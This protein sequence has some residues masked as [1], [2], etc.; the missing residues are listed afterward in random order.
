MKKTYKHL[1]LREREKLYGWLKAGF[2]L[3]ETA[4]RL[5]RD[6]STIS[7]ELKRNAPPIRTGYYLPAKAQVRAL[8]RNIKSRTRLRL[9]NPEIRSYV[10]RKLKQDPS[11]EQIAGRLK[12]EKSSMGISHEAIYQFIYAE[13]RDFIPL[14]A[15]SHRKR[16]KRWHT[17]KHRKSHIPQ[18]VPITQRPR[19]VEARCQFGHWEA[20][21]IISRVSLPSLLVMIE[22]KSR[23]VKLA[24]LPQKSADATRT[25]INRR[26]SQIPSGLRRTVTY[27][28]GSENVEHLMVNETVGTRSYFCLPFHSWEKGAVENTAGLVRRY[29]PKK[30]D[31]D[32][33]SPEQVRRVE[34][35]LNNRPRKCLNFRTPL[36]V[37]RSGVA[38]TG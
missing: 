30:T 34:W 23:Y 6:V 38:L 29:F 14:L 18:R 21:T 20:D 35:R 2:S 17:K 26:L 25:A 11:P 13:A 16:L 9:K 36:E 8:K 33:I 22:R 31:F 3:R 32:T 12:D 24:W 27:D 1:S 19:I 37:F 4:R 15:R 7:R 5:G 10:L 28:N